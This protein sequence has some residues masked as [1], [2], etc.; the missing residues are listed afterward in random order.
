VHRFAN[1]RE[2]I[3][4]KLT[5]EQ[6]EAYKK[7][8]KQCPHCGSTCIMAASW[9]WN[10]T[11]GKSRFSVYCDGC[12]RGW[13]EEYELVS[14]NGQKL[15]VVCAWCQKSDA[16]ATHTICKACLEKHFP[17]VVEATNGSK[18]P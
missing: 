9:E 14:M 12:E 16:E 8:G 2:G 1:L 15:P 5:E 10:K 3:A 13:S 4:L 18:D 11:P 17:E 6:L 7:N